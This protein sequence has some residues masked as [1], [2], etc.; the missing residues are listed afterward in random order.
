MAERGVSCSADQIVITTGAQ[1]GLDILARAL[2]EPGGGV[3][4][5]EVSYTGAAQAIAAHRPR[6]WSVPTC[7]RAGIDIDAVE[8]LL[9]GGVRPAFLYT[10][11]D[12]HN[13]T[14]SCL[15]EASRRRLADLA[16]RFELPLIEDDPYSALRFDG[17][18]LPAVRA[19]DDRWVIYVGSFSKIVAPALRVGWIVVPQ[20]LREAVSIVKEASDL[21]TSALT[22]R[23]LERFLSSNALEPHL[24]RLR[25]SY[26][27]RRDAMLD[28]LERHFP[29]CTRWNRPLGGLFVWVELPPSI[30]ADRL[31]AEAVDEEGVAFIPGSAF[32]TTRD[33]GASAMRL[34]FATCE[35]AE[36]DE[37]VR[38][39]ARVLKGRLRD[40]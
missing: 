8:V 40:E 19:F 32:A 18:A 39:L 14:G 26:R 17:E 12:F 33:A 3:L 22:Q 1:Q 34:S 2:L 35:P 36:I 30:R 23:V 37:A 21:E 7:A 13:P 29:S 5:E 15:T 24:E 38:R 4:M 9:E 27:E 25:H 28:A 6:V 20:G 10:V 16:G 11:P 31:L